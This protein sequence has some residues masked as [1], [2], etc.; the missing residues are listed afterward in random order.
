[1]EICGY[2]LRCLNYGQRCLDCGHQQK[3]NNNDYLHD[4][5]SLCPQGKEAVCI[6]EEGV[7]E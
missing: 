6:D 2:H 4:L 1:M 5:L 3:N 7:A